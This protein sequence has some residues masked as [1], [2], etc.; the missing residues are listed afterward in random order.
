MATPFTFNL[1]FVD[2]KGKVLKDVLL[3]CT[4]VASSSVTDATSGAPYIMVDQDSFI[5]DISSPTP[6]TVTKFKI[7]RNN[8]DMGI[9][10]RFAQVLDSIP[11]T[12]RVP[13]PIAVQKG[14]M[15]NI[16]VS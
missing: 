13:Y 12:G 1:V 6:A 9:N 14:D 3:S 4:D 15:L 8:F 10:K 5:G 16:V 11:I 7:F 2:A